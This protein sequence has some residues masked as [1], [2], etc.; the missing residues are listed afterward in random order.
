MGTYDIVLCRNVAIYFSPQNRRSLFTRLV[1]QL[2]PGGV[3]IVGSTESL[4]GVSPR[5]QREVFHGSV[6]YRKVR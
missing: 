2:R 6:Y 1:D 3:L 5:L 4:L